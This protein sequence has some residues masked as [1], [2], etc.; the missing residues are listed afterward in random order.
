VT[1]FDQQ[2]AAQKAAL[3]DAHARMALVLAK[4]SAYVDRRAAEGDL[5]AIALAEEVA[6]IHGELF[7]ENI[8]AEIFLENHE[9]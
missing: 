5:E 8:A 3:Q 4:C 1:D 7:A 6:E 9:S 2:K